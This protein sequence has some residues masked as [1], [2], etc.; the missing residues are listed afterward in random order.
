[1]GLVYADVDLINFED[2]L[3]ARRHFIGADEIKRISINIL[4]DTASYLLCINENIQDVLQLPFLEKRVMQLANGQTSEYSIVSN[5]ELRFKNRT[6]VCSAVVLPGD[7][8]PLLGVIPLEEMDVLIRPT[9]Q[10]LI[11]NPEH[12]YYAV[13]KLK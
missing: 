10:E 13:L 2:V 1:M 8:E 3:L 9:S 4:V 5:A 7:S 12:P 6:V 11:V